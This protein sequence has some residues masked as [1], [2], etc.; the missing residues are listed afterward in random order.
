MSLGLCNQFRRCRAPSFAYLSKGKVS[1]G[2][3]E[4]NQLRRCR[5]GTPLHGK[6][7]L[8]N[9]VKL[10]LVS[11]AVLREDQG[12]STQTLVKTVV[13]QRNFWQLKPSPSEQQ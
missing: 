5:A 7:E 6:T 3:K 12:S 8:I 13:V 10:T 2:G 1:G 9:L 11:W 4:G